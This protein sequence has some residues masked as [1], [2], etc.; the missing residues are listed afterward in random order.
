[1]IITLLSGQFCVL[2]ARENDLEATGE[3][4]MIEDKSKTIV[5]GLGVPSADFTVI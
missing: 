4:K 5:L 2:E 3:L 1:M